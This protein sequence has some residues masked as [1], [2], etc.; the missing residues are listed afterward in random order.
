MVAFARPSTWMAVLRGLQ[1]LLAVLIC[2]SAYRALTRPAVEVP[3]TTPPADLD[4]APV[5]DDAPKPLDW[6]ACIWQRD[7]RQPPIPPVADQQ[8][9]AP[10]QPAPPLPRLL[11]TFVEPGGRW[12]CFLTSEGRTRTCKIDEVVSAYRITAIEPGRVQL[13]RAGDTQ[14]VELPRRPGNGVVR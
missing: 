8:D 13:A 1:V 4:A 7:L 12:A 2:V 10:T 14:W 3:E 5:A 11:G 9:Q 6:Y